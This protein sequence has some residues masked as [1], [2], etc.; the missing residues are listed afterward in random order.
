LPDVERAD[1]V[2]RLGH[3]L[4]PTFDFFLFSLISGLFF[5]VGIFLD[6]PPLLLLAALFAPVMGPLMGMSLGIVTGSGMYFLR[7]LIGFMLGSLLAFLAGALGGFVSQYLPAGELTQAFDSARLSW[8]NLLVLAI[9]SLF[10]T[11]F[12]AR[13]AAVGRVWSVAL[14]YTLFLPLVTAG[15]GLISRTPFLW[16]DGLVV[17]AIYMSWSVTLGVICLALLGFRPLTLFGYSMSGALTLLGVILAIGM[18]SAGAAFGAQIAL[19]TFTPTAT[20]TLTPSPS[21]TLTPVP[22]TPTATLT[23][24]PPTATLTPTPTL[25][26]T[27][28]ATPLYALVGVPDGAVI[29][30]EPGGRVVASYV[31]G[32]LLQV[33]NPLPVLLGSQSWVLVAGPDGTQGWILQTLL[34]TA[35]PSPNW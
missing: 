6:A 27:Q 31:E 14:A 32:T 25:T 21:P 34:I 7:S 35:T 16:P 23:P 13:S 2:D 9:G 4:A 19:P 30:D 18:S 11:L 10:T 1:T 12:L 17:Y 20:F 28:T 3:R 8:I 33:L 5:C 26:P 15:Y 22:P 29:R 24:V